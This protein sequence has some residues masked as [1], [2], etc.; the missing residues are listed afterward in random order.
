MLTTRE[1]DQG[2]PRLLG[3]AGGGYLLTYTQWFGTNAVDVLA[4][5][6]DANLNGEGSE[7]AVNQHYGVTGP[8][9]RALAIGADGRILAVWEGRTP[10]KQRRLRGRYLDIVD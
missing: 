1:G 7:V 10:G 3:L 6:L 5:H 2:S 8:Y 9:T 4:A